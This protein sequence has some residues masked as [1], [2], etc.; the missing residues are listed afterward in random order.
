MMTSF[1]YNDMSVH[2]WLVTESPYSSHD[3]YDQYGRR[4]E[5]DASRDA[6]PPVPPK[7]PGMTRHQHLPPTHHQIGAIKEDPDMADS[8]VL[9]NTLAQLAATHQC[10]PTIK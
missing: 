5:R 1:A 9:V 2:A 7:S 4:P 10:F 6:A 8:E 3:Q